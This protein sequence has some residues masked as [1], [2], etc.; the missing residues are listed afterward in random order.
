MRRVAAGVGVDPRLDRRRRRGQHHRE[1]GEV[2]AHHRHVAGVVEDA[3][4]LLVGEVVLLI[5]DDQAEL[6][7]RQEQRRA[8]ADHDPHRRRR[9]R[10]ARPA[11]GPAARPPS[12]TRAGREPKRA[13]KRSRNPAVSAISGM[14]DQHLPAAAERL[15]HRLEI[16]LGLARAG[17]AVEQRHRIA[18]GGDRA[19]G[20]TSAAAA[21]SALSSVGAAKSTSGGRATGA[22]GIV[23]PRQRARIDQPVDDA[24]R[25][26]R[27]PRRGPTSTRPCRRRRAPA[28]ALPRRRH[29][30]GRRPGEAHAGDRRFRRERRRARGAPCGAPCRGWSACSAPPSRRRRGS[31]STAAARRTWPT[32]G[33]SRLWPISLSGGSS[34][35]TPT[36]SRRAE[37][38]LDD[39]AGPCSR[40]RAVGVRRVRPRPGT[41]TDTTDSAA[42]AGRI[43]MGQTWPADGE[44]GRGTPPAAGARRAFSVLSSVESD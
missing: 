12:A 23:R 25:R 4:L 40:R 44:N 10:R 9:R 3:L 16:D 30:G 32:I 7:E 11:R 6:G 39:V 13:A 42:A 33:R 38:H 31:P 21:C 27:P 35:T 18:A 14:Q 15:G 26:P 37:R 1:A 22:A 19:R 43:S 29:A 5:D 24:G 36:T 17:D 41:S 2:A 34:Q 28:R 20:A 8:R